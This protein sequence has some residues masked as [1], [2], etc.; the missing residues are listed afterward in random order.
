MTRARSRVMVGRAAELAVLSAAAQRARDGEVGL[1]LVAGEAGIGKSRL[2]SEFVSSLDDALT[3]V[4]HGVAMST[5][6]I[7]FG[8]LA[9]LMKNLL[10]A[11]PDALTPGEQEALAPVLPGTTRGGDRIAMLSAALDL[12]ERLSADRLVL[13]VV[14]D[15]HWADAASRDLLGVALRTAPGHRLL[16]IATVRTDDP[17]RAGDQELAVAREITR[18][19]QLPV[20]E[21]LHLGRLGLADVRRQLAGMELSLDAAARARI[22]KLSRGIPFVVEE[23]AAAGGASEHATHL[24]V[25]RDRLSGLPADALRLVEAAA[26][27]D[28]H[29]RMRLLEQVTDLE[30]DE[31]DRAIQAA[32]ASQEIGASSPGSLMRTP[33]RRPSARRPRCPRSSARSGR[34]AA[35]PARTRPAA[36]GRAPAAPGT[37]PPPRGCARSRR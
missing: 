8:V 32:S 15:L 30:G 24:T 1:V 36:A 3:L 19:G 29:L 33:R 6:E 26:I 13:W 7:P 12:L 10:R 22:E 5:G 28:G 11:D 16:V 25:S 21:T 34:P 35:S 17:A 31:L 23:L 27:G 9:D 14:D 2:V 20:A 37:A 4:S 18:L